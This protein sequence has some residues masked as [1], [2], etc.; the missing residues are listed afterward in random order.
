MNHTKYSRDKNLLM[1][2]I[3]NR[4]NLNKDSKK[5]RTK[6]NRDGIND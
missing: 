6:K 3:S 5:A 4:Y 1:C 2:H